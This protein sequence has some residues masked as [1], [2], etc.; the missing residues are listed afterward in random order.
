M[1]RL[2]LLIIAL[3]VWPLTV[4]ADIYYWTDENGIRHFTN[5]QPPTGAKLFV[6][7]PKVSSVSSQDTFIEKPDAISQKNQ[8]KIDDGS[9]QKQETPKDEKVAVTPVWIDQSHRAERPTQQA[10]N[11][12]D[13]EE[14]R[15]NGVPYEYTLIND[16]DYK[17]LPVVGYKDRY[18]R[19][20]KGYGRYSP[21]RYH[22]PHYST[23]F[24]YGT[25]YS[26]GYHTKIPYKRPY[27]KRYK[28]H[29]GK[30]DYPRHYG[31]RHYYKH[32][33]YHKRHIG[34]QRKYH[35][36]RHKFRHHHT[37]IH[38]KH[39]FHKRSIHRSHAKSRFRSFG[40]RRR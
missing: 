25:R 26:Y 28:R 33:K 10:L 4:S 11:Q 32:P 15:T 12:T 36:H 18:G 22:R 3:L 34:T 38:R 27:Y 14:D 20:S 1:K 7:A 16:D 35:S 17:I 40:H 24:R 23:I 8:E 2:L 29:Y 39:Q 37:G 6:K 13:C 9:L 19:Y 30:Y 21:D 31:R 5:S